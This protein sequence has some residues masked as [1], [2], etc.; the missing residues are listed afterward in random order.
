[1]PSVEETKVTFSQTM[2][3]TTFVFRDINIRRDKGVLM[4]ARYRRH[5]STR[6]SGTNSK[7][8]KEAMLQ[9]LLKMLMLTWGL[10]LFL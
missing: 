10:Y 9:M 5:P 8:W 3:H 1:M 2:A 7:P 4:V 6:C